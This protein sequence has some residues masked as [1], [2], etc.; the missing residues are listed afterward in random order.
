MSKCT[1]MLTLLK[2]VRW[3]RF[4]ITCLETSVS[5]LKSP[6]LCSFI[7]NSRF[8]IVTLAEH[9]HLLCLVLTLLPTISWPLICLT[10]YLPPRHFQ[11]APPSPLS[12]FYFFFHQLRGRIV[13]SL[14]QCSPVYSLSTLFPVG[15]VYLH[16]FAPSFLPAF[17]PFQL[18]S[19]YLRY[20]PACVSLSTIL[21]ASS[22]TFLLSF[23]SCSH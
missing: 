2:P 8:G 12:L 7:L 11:P 21:A 9:T 3:S 16:S 19:L 15:T 17:S 18:L 5:F 14:L 20:Q 10:P 13:C 22:L 1:K 4:S 6:G 23:F